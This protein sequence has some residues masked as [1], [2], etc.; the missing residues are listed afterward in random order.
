MS[1]AYVAKSRAV[2]GVPPGWPPNETHVPG[3][4]YPPADGDPPRGSYP[5]YPYPGE[6]IDGVPYFPDPPFPYPPGYSPDFSIVTA[7]VGT[8]VTPGN[9]VSVTSTIFDHSDYP[10]PEPSVVT[11]TAAINGVTVRLKI[12]GGSFSNFVSRSASFEDF[13]AVEESVV[14]DLDSGDDGKTLILTS[15]TTVEEETITTTTEILVGT[16][17]SATITASWSTP[18]NLLN[19]VGSYPENFFKIF[20]GLETSPGG[21][22]LSWYSSTFRKTGNGGSPTFDWVTDE[23]STS[24]VVVNGDETSMTM[25]ID[26]LED[27]NS[28]NNFHLDATARNYSG[29]CNGSGLVS[30]KTYENGLLVATASLDLLVTRTP[31]VPQDYHRPWATVDVSDGTITINNP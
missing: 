28:G 26:S 18:S 9:A 24:S 19:W 15:T 6:P 16:F 27:V 5:Y 22:L 10:T 12:A 17:R 3:G 25:L 30:M 31:Y 11:W 7:F 13:W 4:V 8:A 21:S 14:F 23:H 29:K 20:F 1:G 2:V